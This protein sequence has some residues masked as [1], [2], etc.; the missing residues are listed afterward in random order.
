[1]KNRLLRHRVVIAPENFLIISEFI[2]K[3]NDYFSCYEYHFWK[4]SQVNFLR[5][6]N[7]CELK[8]GG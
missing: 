7:A 5:F 2:N 4:S 3:F 6:W 1:M 8:Q